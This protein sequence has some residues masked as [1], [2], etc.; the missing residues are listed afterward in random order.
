MSVITREELKQYCLRSLGAPVIEIN[1]DEDQLEDRIDD[2]LE[3]WHQYHSDGTEKVYLKHL[4]TA[5]DMTNE[6]ITVPDLVVGV[7]NVLSIGASTNNPFDSVH[8]MRLLDLPNLASTELISYTTAMSYID[9]IK[10]ELTKQ[11]QLRF[12]RYQGK[13]YLD[14]VWGEAVKEG[15]YI[16]FEC[17]RALDPVEYAKLWGEPWLKHYTT[18]LF[19]RMWATNLKKFSGLILPGGVQLD[20]QSLYDESIGEIKDLEDELMNKS[21]PLNFFLG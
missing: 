9:L 5:T 2:A 21:A 8:Q 4:V 13:A 11:F 10:F 20:G 18:A 6:Y 1:V 14:I 3:Y 16:I 17:Y 12:N 15:E 19:K 7:T